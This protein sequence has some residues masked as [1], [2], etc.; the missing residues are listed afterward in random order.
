MAGAADLTQT[1]T[2]LNRYLPRLTFTFTSAS[3]TEG[4]SE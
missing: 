1:R 3:K 4:E 2:G